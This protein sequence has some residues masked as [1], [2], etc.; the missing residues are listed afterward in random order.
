MSKKDC[1]KLLS[2]LYVS[3]L[4]AFLKRFGRS[5]SGRKQELLT[6]ATEVVNSR[7]S[8][9]KTMAAFLRSIR[10]RTPRY[11]NFPHHVASLD[12]LTGLPSIPGFGS[13][14]DLP[15]PPL[16]VNVPRMKANV[17]FCTSVYNQLDQHVLA[18]ELLLGVSTGNVHSKYASYQI[19]LNEE[20][21]KKVGD[22]QHKV[23]LR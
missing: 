16:E 10:P 9:V 14:P 18:P 6:R 5:T 4:K 2:K 22:G 17:A 21:R 23:L 7:N 13:Y 3:D 12:P 15:L 8:D 11:T 1:T 19:T 20:Q